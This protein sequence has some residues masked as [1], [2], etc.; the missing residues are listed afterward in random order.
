MIK[1]ASEETL[2]SLVTPHFRF[3]ELCCPC[4]T[5]MHMPLAMLDFIERVRN[6]Y[7]RKMVLTS[8]VRCLSH[9]YAVG[10][11]PTSAHVLGLA[12]DVSCRDS[13]LRRK[14]IS[15]GEKA[16]VKGLGLASDFIHLDIHQRLQGDPCWFY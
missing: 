2:A 5:K 4:C 9:N 3:S 11:K 10:S 6:F 13:F 7:D 1:K 16:G 14:L 12:I 15:A 8:A